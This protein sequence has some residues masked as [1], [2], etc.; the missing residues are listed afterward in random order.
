MQSFRSKIGSDFQGR[1]HHLQ[2]E[3]PPHEAKKISEKTL[4]PASFP[5]AGLL[6]LTFPD[7]K[8]YKGQVGEGMYLS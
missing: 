2:F 7:P 6:H 8:K 1:R 3:G 5:A 4:D